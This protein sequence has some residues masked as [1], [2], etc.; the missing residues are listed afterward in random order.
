MFSL[1]FRES[2]MKTI[3]I[4]RFGRFCLEDLQ[5]LA[6]LLGKSNWWIPHTLV[7]LSFPGGPEG[8]ESACDVGD[9]S[10][11]IDPWV[12]KIPWRREWLPTP[13]FLPGEFQEQR[14]L[15]G[16]SPWSRKESDT[17]E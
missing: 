3:K 6:A 16:Y 11:E 8:E 15:A 2:T 10:L 9:R 12:E 5:S 4:F 7:V 1:Y 13:V 17:T 14:S